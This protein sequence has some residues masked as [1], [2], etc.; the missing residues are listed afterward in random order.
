MLSLADSRE[1]RATRPSLTRFLAAVDELCVLRAKCECALR[2]SAD[3]GLVTDCRARPCKQT[4]AALL[5][6]PGNRD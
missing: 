5:A 6:N 4:H 2:H 3:L 1:G